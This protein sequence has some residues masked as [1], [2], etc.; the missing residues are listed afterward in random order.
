MGG[1]GYVRVYVYKEEGGKG[2]GAHVRHVS[3]V[4]ALHMVLVAGWE[5][6]S[7]VVVGWTGGDRRLGR[8][9]SESRAVR[10]GGRVACEEAGCSLGILTACGMAVSLLFGRGLCTSGNEV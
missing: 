7:G 9:L 3:H 5:G 1:W 2:K 4:P 8:A 10:G 6:G